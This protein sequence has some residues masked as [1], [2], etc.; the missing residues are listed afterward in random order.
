MARTPTPCSVW[1]LPCL[2]MPSSKNQL[3]VTAC[4][5][6]RSAA[7]TPGFIRPLSTRWMRDSSSSPGARRGQ[8]RGHHAVTF[9]LL[10][11]DFAPGIENQA[12]AVG[13]A[14]AGVDTVL[15]GRDEEA[16]IF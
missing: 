8:R 4:W 3:S 7:S 1:W 15:A 6:Y 2:T 14:A 11:Q 5:K 13:G 16:L 10:R 12:V 9:G